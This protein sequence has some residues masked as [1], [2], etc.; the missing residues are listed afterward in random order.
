M[1]N[2]KK[3]VVLNNICASYVYTF[4]KLDFIYSYNTRR[5][6]IRIL[7]D[8]LNNFCE[9]PNVKKASLEILFLKL[10]TINFD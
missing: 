2:R 9:I 3:C 5:V 10:P 4:L 1:G 6:A 7:A 8:R